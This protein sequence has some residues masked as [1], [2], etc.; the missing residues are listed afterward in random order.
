M[1]RPILY[2]TTSVVFLLLAVSFLGGTVFWRLFTGY[3]DLNIDGRAEVTRTSVL[4]FADQWSSYGGDPGGARYSAA[5][6]INLDNVEKLDVAWAYRTGAFEEREELISRTAFEATPIL[7]ED[8]LIFCTP[9]NEII[10][11]DPGNGAEK[12]RYDP[13]VQT[14][15]RPANDFTCRGVA[16]WKDQTASMAPCASRIYTGTVDSRLIA[17]DAKSGEL[18]TDFGA[19]GA[20]QIEPSISLRWPGEY[21]ITSAPTIIGNTVII[22]SAISDNLRTVAPS[23][24]VKAFDVRTGA[25]KWAFD[26]VPRDP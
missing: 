7:V 1:K 5:D 10:A 26:P 4:A 6:Q 8:A 19:G 22:G 24:V 15:G 11:I 23:G 25:E 2:I 12:W 16:Y 14:D 3:E 21:Q 13:E 17:L 20:V 18:C 9:F